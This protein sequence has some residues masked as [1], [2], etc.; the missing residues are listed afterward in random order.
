MVVFDL[1]AEAYAIDIGTVSA[2]I[3]MQDITRVPRMPDFVEG[4]INLRGKVIPVVDLHERFGLPKRE[5]NKDN[6]IV[7]VDIDGQDIGMI[8]DAVREVI[9]IAS[10]AV[11]PPSSVI[12]TDRSKYVQGIAKLE[13]RL[14]ILLDLS[15]IFTDQE[16]VTLSDRELVES[17]A[18]A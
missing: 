2:I 15:Q 12:T 11:E 4:V 17:G 18:V 1:E 6:R 9:R 10:D 5:E 13:N 16:G 7:V 14:I 3:L 8:V